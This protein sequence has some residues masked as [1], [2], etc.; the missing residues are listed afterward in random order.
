MSAHTRQDQRG[1]TLIEVLVVT[2]LLGLL[3]G[4]LVE[5]TSRSAE[6]FDRGTRGQD[7]ADEALSAARRL[8]EQFG[9]LAGPRPGWRGEGLPDARLLVH[10]APLGLRGTL[11]PTDANSPQIAAPRLQVLRSTV[12]L[13]AAQEEALLRVAV[14]AFLE[15]TEGQGLDP[16]VVEETI[17]SWPRRG[18]GELLMLP[19]PTDDRGVFMEL[20]V[21]ERLADPELR[22]PGEL[23]LVDIATVED[24]ELE[25]DLVLQTTRPVLRGLLHF[26]VEFWSQR[27]TAWTGGG[28][29]GT[30][31]SWDSARAG[32]LSSG[33][34]L[35]TD[36]A[37]DLGEASLLDARDDVWPRWARITLVVSSGPGAVPPSYLSQPLAA[38]DTEFRVSRPDDL[39][40]AGENPWLKIDNEW[41]HFGD[42]NGSNVLNV[43]RGVRG[44]TARSHARGTPVREGR[45]VVLVIPLRC[46]KDG[47]D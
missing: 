15:R 21:G 23:G 29:Q 38:T 32:L 1:F 40:D 8:R 5:L 43:R 16:E 27:T 18:R 10:P 24:L 3:L 19:W 31:V 37:L 11:P 28:S 36:F 20:R 7:R 9:D 17:A 47:D 30:Q 12:Q 14:P 42:V 25:R 26:E 13:D 35:P 22:E 39:P 6:L 34:D 41:I 2:G 33:T 44:T 46:G 45:M 4:A